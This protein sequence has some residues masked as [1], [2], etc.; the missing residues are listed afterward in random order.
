MNFGKRWGGKFVF[1]MN[2]LCDLCELLC[3]YDLSV[4]ATY[5]F[6]YTISLGYKLDCSMKWFGGGGW[7]PF[8][9][10]SKKNRREKKMC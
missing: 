5:I 10:R 6:I 7:L 1:N 8:A 4:Y 2:N 9:K 3:K